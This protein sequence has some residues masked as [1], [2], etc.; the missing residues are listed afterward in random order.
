MS[1]FFLLA[2][3]EA[4]KTADRRA[5]EAQLT[6]TLA[7]YQEATWFDGGKWDWWQLGGR[8][9][10]ELDGYEPEKDP[11]NIE[12]CDLCAGS[13]KRLDGMKVANGCNGC[14]GKG[15][16]VKWPTQWRAHPGD[17]QLLEDI[18]KEVKP[19][20]ILTPDGKWYEKGEMGWW[21]IVSNQKEETGWEAT[22]V[23]LMAQYKDCLAVVI[24]CHI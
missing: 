15:K 21:G 12:L 14:S 7:K 23:A 19:F 22:K 9:T 8:W 10:G 24:D 17:I 13:G 2:L 18:K 20:A 5:L 4:P 16:R 6:K 11:A 1:H 3:L